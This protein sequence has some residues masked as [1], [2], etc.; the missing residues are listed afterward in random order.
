M[1]TCCH[2]G[3]QHTSPERS[4]GTPTQHLQTALGPSA[5]FLKQ[6]LFFAASAT[7]IP[8]R[9]SLHSTHNPTQALWGQTGLRS[10][11]SGP[12]Q[13]LPDGSTCSAN[14]CCSPNLK[15]VTPNSASVA[16]SSVP[17][18]IRLRDRHFAA[19]RPVPTICKGKECLCWGHGPGASA[20]RLALDAVFDE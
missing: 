19:P 3:H 7:S 15:E 9:N 14:H 16:V 17:T 13:R 4:L 12:A 8:R 2:R 10:P 1:N 6:Q 20:E 18:P 5:H 11:R